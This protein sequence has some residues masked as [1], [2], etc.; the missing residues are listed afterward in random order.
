MNDEKV[1]IGTRIA[2]HK[3]LPDDVIKN[4]FKSRI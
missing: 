3:Q 4:K 2:N 1:R